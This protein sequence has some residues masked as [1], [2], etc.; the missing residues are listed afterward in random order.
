MDRKEA[1]K[2]CDTFERRAPGRRL[3]CKLEGDRMVLYG[4]AYGPHSIDIRTSDAKR[5]EAHWR[6]YA[7][8]SDLLAPKIGELVQFPSGSSRTGT[9]Y[10]RVLKVGPK[11][12]LV[13]YRYKHGGKA[14]PKWVP[15][16]DLVFAPRR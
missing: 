14:A 10:G 4:G 8:A 1:E 12:A 7:E 6:G 9:R 5:A 15:F 13:E 11:R 2:L 16:Q 3:R